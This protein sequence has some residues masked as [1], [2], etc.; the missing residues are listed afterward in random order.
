[1]YN[2]ICYCN[3]YR[4]CRRLGAGKCTG[5]AWAESIFIYGHSLCEKCSQHTANYNGK[6]DVADGIASLEDCPVYRLAH[7]L[8]RYPDHI[9]PLKNI[10]AT[11]EKDLLE[12]EEYHYGCYDY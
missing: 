1:M 11:L 5:A 8:G 9:H 10:N 3:V 2:V 6:C 4:G 7:E 12:L